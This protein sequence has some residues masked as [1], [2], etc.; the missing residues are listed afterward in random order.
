MKTAPKIT[1]QTGQ[2]LRYET[3]STRAVDLTTDEETNE[4]HE[5]RVGETRR[6]AA[7]TGQ[8]EEGEPG[9]RIAPCRLEFDGTSVE[10]VAGETILEAGRRAGIDI[11]AMCADPRMKPTGDCELCQIALDGEA[12]LVK[13]CMTPAV[14]GMRVQTRNSELTALR[15]DR[16]NTYLADH[17]AYCQPPCTAACPAGIDIAGYID[18]I[19]QKDYVGSTALIKEMLPFPGVLGRVCP[20][21][22]EDPCRRVQIDGKP[23]AICALK[24]FAA[25]K[26]AETGLPTQPEPEPPTGKRVA[27]VGAGATGLSAAYYLA[28]EGHQVTL[29]ESEKKAGGM[30]RFGIPP[31]RLP[32]SVL[33]QE[34]NDILSLG[35]E[36]RTNQT[37]GRDYQIDTLK[38]QGFDAIYLSIGAMAAKPT[39]IPGDAAEGVM[40]AIKFLADVNRNQPVNV[41]ERVIVIGGGFTAADAVRTARRVGA[42]EVTMMYRRTRKEMS[43]AAHEI[44]ECDVEGVKF[45][46]LAAPVS[47]KVENGR[48]VGLTSRRMELGEPDDSGRRRPVPIPGTEY[49]TP[50]NTILMAI[51]Q[52]VDV[53]ALQEGELGLDKRWGTIEVDESTMMTNLPGV[54]SGGDC[55]TGAATVVEGVGAA[56][57]GALAINAYLNGAG[58]AGIA[59]AIFRHK[60]DFFDIGA[61]AASAVPMNHMPVLD[62]DARLEAFENSRHGGDVDNNEAFKE[63]ETGFSEETALQEAGRCLMCRCQAAGVC[64]LQSLSI[65]YGAGTKAYLG[66][67]AWK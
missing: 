45:D 66:K 25:D 21:P 52:D 4:M 24:R 65:K 58:E 13:A 41:G 59:A 18:L 11:P 53:A 34:I 37:M 43:A 19:L 30:L 67:D 51:G 46:F 54:F 26:A 17:N 57:L 64:T 44:H 49:F 55:V 63:V 35:V 10:A 27:V 40:S 23:V 32:N 38:D 62:G 42:S 60:P 22:C 15:R 6:R 47:V 31:Y 9:G 1:D 7:G 2:G 56:R 8:R 5:D 16:L 12:D 50:A 48:V 29:L 28:L 33:D 20:R 39:G 61:K 36:L 3:T 14:E